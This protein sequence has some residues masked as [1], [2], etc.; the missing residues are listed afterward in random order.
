MTLVAHNKPD[1]RTNR[2]VNRAAAGWRMS[3]DPRAHASDP[4]DH[5]GTGRVAQQPTP[6]G[7]AALESGRGLPRDHSK[8]ATLRPSCTHPHHRWYHLGGSAARA[9]NGRLG[10]SYIESKDRPHPSG[11]HGHHG[12]HQ[13]TLIR[14]RDPAARHQYSSSPFARQARA[15]ASAAASAAAPAERSGRSCPLPRQLGSR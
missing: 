9:N 10:S 4:R 5:R 3:H 1:R 13:P 11:H 14:R 8:T 12:H 15:A 2:Y 6:A 7:V